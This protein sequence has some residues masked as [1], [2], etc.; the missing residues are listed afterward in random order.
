MLLTV[1]LPC[2]MLWGKHVCPVS[3]VGGA[4]TLTISCGFYELFFVGLSSCIFIH[5]PPY[6]LFDIL[7]FTL[8]LKRSYAVYFFFFHITCQLLWSLHISDL[9][10]S[11]LSHGKYGFSWTRP[12]TTV[13]LSSLHLPLHP[14]ARHPCLFVFIHSLLTQSLLPPPNTT[15]SYPHPGCTHAVSSPEVKSRLL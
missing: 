15:H 7:C 12:L 10:A 6:S 5:A 4:C 14:Y 11:F 9:F 1:H 3:P 2:S 13:K 8:L